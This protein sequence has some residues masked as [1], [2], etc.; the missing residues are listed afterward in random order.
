MKEEGSVQSLVKKE[1]RTV[2]QE[3]VSAKK[4]EKVIRTE[5][6]HVKKDEIA[7]K[8]DAAG[9]GSTGADVDTLCSEMDRVLSRYMVLLDQRNALRE[10]G[11]AGIRQG[12]ASICDAQFECMTPLNLAKSSYEGREMTASLRIQDQAGGKDKG[13][14]RQLA[15]V[16]S[17]TD[18]PAPKNIVAQSIEEDF[19]WVDGEV[20]KDEVSGLRKRRGDAPTGSTT[21]TNVTSAS[22]TDG[23]KA[24]KD[25]PAGLVCTLAPYEEP[26]K[27]T[28][29]PLQWFGTLVPPGLRKA[30]SDF[31]S[32]LGALVELVNADRQLAAMES[33]MNFLKARKQRIV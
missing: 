7:V 17:L 23:A 3:E 13:G 2:K 14:A 1:E 4:D 21:N 15:L 31:H 29:P 9:T 20:V 5:E 10:Q 11:F 30:K 26:T 28:C 6:Q 8:K 22:S 19:V 24:S 33:E 27:I 25:A 32:S 18:A 16:E 12:L